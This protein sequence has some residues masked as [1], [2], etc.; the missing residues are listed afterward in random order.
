[1]QAGVNFEPCQTIYLLTFLQHLFINDLGTSCIMSLLKNATIQPKIASSG[2]YDIMITLPVENIGLDLSA[3]F[4][5]I[6]VE[7]QLCPLVATHE[8][9]S[10]DY[11]LED[12]IPNNNYTISIIVTNNCGETFEYS[13][14]ICK[15]NQYLKKSCHS[16]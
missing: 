1:M 11:I 5:E 14:T 4:C 16:I 8:G 6:R 2:H 3:Y 10:S 12:V 15:S 7:C 9:C 13:R